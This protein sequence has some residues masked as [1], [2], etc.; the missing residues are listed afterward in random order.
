M[1]QGGCTSEQLRRNVGNVGSQKD[2][3]AFLT[4]RRGEV[5]SE[6][7]RHPGYH[8]LTKNPWTTPLASP[9]QLRPRVIELMG[10]V[11]RLRDQ[12]QPAVSGQLA[13]ELVAG[14][15]TLARAPVFSDWSKYWLFREH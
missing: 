8:H 10:P 5:V 9:S 3:R 1:I 2:F 12:Y 13:Q 11:S 7:L 6:E 15:R 4:H 14:F